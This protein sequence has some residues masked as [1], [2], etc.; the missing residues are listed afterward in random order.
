MIN[1]GVQ[2]RKKILDILVKT[3]KWPANINTTD[4]IYIALSKTIEKVDRK[5]DNIT[6]KNSQIASHISEIS[7]MNQAIA[8]SIRKINLLGI[9]KYN[10]CYQEEGKAADRE[11]KKIYLNSVI[12]DIEDI[13]QQMT[14]LKHYI[15]PNTILVNNTYNKIAKESETFEDIKGNIEK[16]W[17]KLA[18]NFFQL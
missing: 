11:G 10:S 5:N 13:K 17:G 2:L 4:V 7:D 9:K 18:L 14:T 6:V 3:K 8:T 12:L 1:V 15:G 16:L